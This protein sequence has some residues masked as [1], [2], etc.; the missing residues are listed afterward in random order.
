MTLRRFLAASPCVFLLCAELLFP[1]TS[2]AQMAP[3]PLLGQWFGQVHYG[4]ESK[5]MGMR[6]ERS[7]KHP[8]F[9]FEDIPELKFNNL[10]PLPVQQQGDAYKISAIPYHTITFRLASDK[11]SVTGV[12]SFDGHD[13]PF[14][15]KPGALP[16]EAAPQ[17]PAGRVA[18]PAWTFKTA[19]AIWSSPAEAGNTVY[20]GSIDGIIYALKADSGKQVWQFKT[21]G[22]VMGAPTIEG[23]YLYELSDDGSL[24]KL[25]RR[26]GKL[27]WQFDTHGG[28]VV[29]DLAGR[30]DTTTS[31]ATVA[32][33]TVFIGSADK[34]L[35]AVDA[36]SGREKWHFDTQDI[37]R[38][39]PAVADGRVFIGSY[40]HN[41]YAVDAQT[42]SL[43]WKYDTLRDVVSSPLVVDGAV[44]IG[45][46]SADLFALDAAT[47]KIKWKFFY[48]SSWVES[49]A[50]ARDAIL[51]VG[52]SD[53][54][55]LFAIDAASGKQIWN[56]DADGS[57]WATP[58]VTGKRV[59]V[60]AVGVPG[61]FVPHHG[62]FFAVDRAT[63][64]EV[65]RFPMP[66][67]VGKDTYG[68]ASSPAVGHGL[69]FFG[70]LDGMF[71]AFRTDD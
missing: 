56:F 10:G 32:D 57:V 26:T 36:Q 50:S 22:P 25:E 28:P 15:L 71:Y 41:V 52:S 8:L 9:V 29:R 18:Q 42:G 6:F 44:Y 12:W 34:R 61:Y 40:D 65:W 63:A 27:L 13:L 14:E 66:V 46:R 19:G 23:R 58:A 62:G 49:S 39:K 51:Y 68:V 69:V 16:A 60:G 5:R 17:P 20:F 35:Y 33:G 31:A 54:Q 43:Q 37:V 67:I 70:G 47:G 2:R 7:E 59:Y 4:A 21:N 11:K 64:K 3:N 48:W 55:Q 1:V 24:Y 30:Y 53:L 38:S 45:S